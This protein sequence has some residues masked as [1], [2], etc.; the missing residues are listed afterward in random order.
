MTFAEARTSTGPAVPAW[1][2]DDVTHGLNL[3]GTE[4]SRWSPPRIDVFRVAPDR[5]GYGLASS[6]REV[7]VRGGRYPTLA[8]AKRAALLDA[9]LFFPRARRPVL[10]ALLERCDDPPR[11]AR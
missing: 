5:W 2:H 4:G 6:D 11:P 1:S 8:K 3:D 10:L 7:T 9:L